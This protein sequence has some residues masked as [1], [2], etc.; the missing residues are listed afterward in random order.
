MI[1]RNGKNTPVMTSENFPSRLPAYCVEKHNCLSCAQNTI[2]FIQA[3]LPTLEAYRSYSIVYN[4][5]HRQ[6]KRSEA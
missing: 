6:A 5:A 4:A 2:V 1:L 3:T